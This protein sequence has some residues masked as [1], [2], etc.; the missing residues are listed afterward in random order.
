MAVRDVTS[1]PLAELFRLQGRSAVVTG[2]AKGI[3]AAV[4]ERLA[5]AGCD[6]VLGDVDESGLSALA[7]GLMARHHVKVVALPLDVTDSAA[8]AAVADRAMAEFGRLDVWVNNAG[9]FPPGA[10]LEMTDEAWEHVLAVNLRGSSVGA[11]EAA[12]RMADAGTAGVIVNVAS[13]AGFRASEAGMP[14]Y[15]ASKHAVIG[16]TKALAAE[17]GPRG[18]RVLG[19]APTLI[20]TPGIADLTAGADDALRGMLEAF[21]SKLPVRRVGVPDDVARVVLFCASDASML[22]TGSTLAV[23]GGALAV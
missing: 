10:T 6:L 3:G 11:R 22:M 16:L 17:L 14:H 20:S 12:R 21:A 5:E 4:A 8:V 23:D 9:I 18:I 13:T 15:I 7:E 19:V 2:A 1:V